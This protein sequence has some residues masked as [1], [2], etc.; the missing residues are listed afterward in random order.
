MLASRVAARR[1]RLTRPLPLPKVT[2]H[3]L[4]LDAAAGAVL[5]AFAIDVECGGGVYVRSLVADIARAC[6][7]RAHMTHLVRTQQGPFVL[8][9]CLPE[10]RWT[11]AELV[12][13]TIPTENLD[14]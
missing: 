8:E 14:P 3:A 10:D 1:P 12:R 5:P 6:D 7:S 4:A 13:K 11:Y 2:V 9:D